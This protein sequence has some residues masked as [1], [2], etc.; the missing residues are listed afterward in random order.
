MKNSPAAVPCS[1][2][3]EDVTRV[4]ALGF[5]RDKTTADKF[6][7]RVITRNGKITDE[8]MATVAKASRLFGSGEIAMTTR[9][10]LEIQGVSYDN[11]QPLID[12]LAEN[13]LQTGGTGKKVR[14]VVSCKGTTC[15]Y[16][17]IDT[18][19]ISKEIHDLFFIGYHDVTLP[20]KFKIAVG[21]CPNNCIKPELN[22][23]GII[24]RKRPVVNLDKC[25]GCGKCQIAVNCPIKI[26]K[27]DDGKVVIDQDLCN[28]C[29]R[30]SGRCPF[31]AVEEYIVG[32]T[33]CI[34]GRWGKKTAKAFTLEKFFTD[35]KDVISTVEKALLLFK[36][37][38]EPGER[39]ADTIA[40]IGF[41]KAN[42]ILLSDE[43]LTR[44]DEIINK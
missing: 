29:G 23:I 33:I 43:I 12:Y 41:E 44:K 2:K 25:R 5:L 31:G 16:G 1:I 27:V 9:L 7:G 3:P 22:D 42:E 39:F 13:G 4:K 18:Y 38:G 36:D 17:L 28:N 30:C 6:N 8:E 24:G 32:C 15:Q 26:A 14:P 34:G 40:R 20:H 37:L 10:T 35:R 19:S 11:I 21:G